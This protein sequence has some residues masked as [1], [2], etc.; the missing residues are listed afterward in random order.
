M[1]VSTA[2]GYMPN[3]LVIMLCGAYSL[4]IYQTQRMHTVYLFIKQPL[5]LIF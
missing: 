5:Y 2:L 3:N 1:L 4:L